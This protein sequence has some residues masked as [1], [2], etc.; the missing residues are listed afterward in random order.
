MGVSF[1]LLVY[2]GTATGDFFPNDFVLTG[3]LFTGQLMLGDL[4]CDFLPI[5]ET[6][7]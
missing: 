7:E 2:V 5:G 3:D 1:R 6:L 4:D